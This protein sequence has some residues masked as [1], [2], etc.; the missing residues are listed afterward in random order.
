VRRGGA[1]SSTTI[2]WGMKV[3]D[4]KGM[5]GELGGEVILMQPKIGLRLEA[6]LDKIGR[7]V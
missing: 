6:K 4:K 5:R 3:S 2:G 7:Q 1:A